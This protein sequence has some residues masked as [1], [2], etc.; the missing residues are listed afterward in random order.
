LGEQSLEAID[1]IRS[2]LSR[3]GSARDALVDEVPEDVKRTF[4][5][6]GIPEQERKFLAG[7]KRNSIA[8]QSIQHQESGRRTGVIL[9]VRPKA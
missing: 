7:V 1:F 4:E 3:A 8:K 9:S 5:R 6:L 2:L